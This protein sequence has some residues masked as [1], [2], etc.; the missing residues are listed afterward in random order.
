MINQQ[1]CIFGLLSHCNDQRNIRLFYSSLSFFICMYDFKHVAMTTSE[2]YFLPNTRL[3][4]ADNHLFGAL[5]LA[6]LCNVCDTVSNLYVFEIKLQTSN[7]FLS[8]VILAKRQSRYIQYIS[9]MIFSLINCNLL[10][11]LF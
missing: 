5:I 3:N 7:G 6:S 9:N 8:G 11:Y 1:K 2:V 10:S 4:L